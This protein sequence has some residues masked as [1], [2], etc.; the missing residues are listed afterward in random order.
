M[1]Y[2]FSQPVAEHG[3]KLFD[4]VVVNDSLEDCIDEIANIAARTFI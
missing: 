3:A 1:A 4:E 2:V